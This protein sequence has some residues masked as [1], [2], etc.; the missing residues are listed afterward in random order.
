MQSVERE[1]GWRSA[2]QRE[3]QLGR[4]PAHRMP[5][6]NKAMGDHVDRGACGVRRDDIGRA[7]LEE[8]S[9]YTPDGRVTWRLDNLPGIQEKPR[10]RKRGA[11]LVRADCTRSF[12]CDVG[13][14]ARVGSAVVGVRRVLFME[15]FRQVEDEWLK[16][17]ATPSAN[18]P[19]YRAR[20]LCMP[21]GRFGPLSW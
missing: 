10:R 5:V 11:N 9:G 4:Q 15:G 14:D 13:S 16:G 17:W 1:I 18:P 8:I 7:A 3:A 6:I 2:L 20:Q 12:C 19:R 21:A